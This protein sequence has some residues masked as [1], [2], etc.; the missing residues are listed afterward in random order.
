MG[1]HTAA[2][3]EIARVLVRLDYVASFHRKRESQG[4]VNG[5]EPFDRRNPRAIGNQIDAAVIFARADFVNV[6]RIFFA[7]LQCDRAHGVALAL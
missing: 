1:V 6:H 3:S 7:M 4:D 2:R 5:C